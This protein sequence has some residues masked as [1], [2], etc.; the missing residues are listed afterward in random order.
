[1][2]ILHMHIYTHTH[3]HL[4]RGNRKQ[5]RLF[6][7]TPKRQA[8]IVLSEGARGHI[9]GTLCVP[10]CCHYFFVGWT[11]EQFLVR[12]CERQKVRGSARERENET[13]AKRDRA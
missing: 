8:R 6:D 4:S 9:V 7:D 13:V 5:F 3:T 2:Y 1:M 12:L 11:Y 10:A